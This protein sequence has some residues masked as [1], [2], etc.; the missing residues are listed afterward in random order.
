MEVLGYD[1][2]RVC[3]AP[4]TAG[5][6][7]HTKKNGIHASGRYDA[8]VGRFI[9]LAGSEIALSRSVL[10]NQGAIDARR[11][12][13]GC[14]DGPGK[15]V[16]TDDLEFASPSTAAIFVLGGSQNGWTEWVSED[17]KTLSDVYRTEG[18]HNE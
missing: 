3:E 11:N 5:A 2:D 17:G 12:M 14:T 18:Q 15:A 1:L 7:F 4:K 13:F 8:G 16:T 10:K 6:V 9:V